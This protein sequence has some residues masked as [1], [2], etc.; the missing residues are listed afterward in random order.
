MQVVKWNC[1]SSKF[2]AAVNRI[3]GISVATIQPFA[4][5]AMA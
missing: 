4:R 2:V 5:F 3:D 1:G